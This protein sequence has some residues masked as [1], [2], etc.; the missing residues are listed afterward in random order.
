MGRLW[1]EDFEDDG[2]EAIRMYMVL[3]FGDDDCTA[4]MLG[5]LASAARVDITEVC[6]DR[7]N[8][9]SRD[10]LISCYIR[11]RVMSP[12]YGEFEQINFHT[13]RLL[14]GPPDSYLL[15]WVCGGLVEN[16]FYCS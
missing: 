6:G 2:G 1:S 12:F 10:Q 9:F 15:H 13:V 4:D 7:G 8:E 14:S 16:L 5:S 3:L 11:W